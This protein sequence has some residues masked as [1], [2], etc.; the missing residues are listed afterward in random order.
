MVN[1][2]LRK[3]ICASIICLSISPFRAFAGGEINQTERHVSQSRSS[4]I[5]KVTTANLNMRTGAGTNY[6]IITTIPNGQT[7][8]VLSSSSGWHKV[9]YSN[10]TG[11]VSS[12]YLKDVETVTKYKVTTTVLN[13]RNNSS[14]TSN[15]IGKLNK[16]TVVEVVSIINNQWAKIKY[17]NSYAYCSTDYLSKVVS[18]QE[19]I[20]ESTTTNT[21]KVT[22]D[23]NLR[24][25][26]NWSAQSI[27]VIKK[28][29][30]VSVISQDSLWSY[31]K[32][33]QQNGYIYNSYLKQISNNTGT[34]TTK[35][36][37]TDA[38]NVRDA[39]NWSAK[40]LGV[41]AKG[42][43][44]DV[45][46]INNGWAKIKYNGNYGY[47]S[48]TYI[49][50]VT[51]ET[52][53]L[54]IVTESVNL[55]SEKSWSSSK[56]TVINKNEKVKVISQDK[57]WTYV[58][59]N[60]KKGYIPSK[61]VEGYVD[62][63][64]SQVENEST[65]TI[66]KFTTDN[67]NMRTG[68]GTNYSIITTIPANTEVTVLETQGSWDKIKY[69]NKIGFVNNNYLTTSGLIASPEYKNIL[70][71]LDAGHGGTDPGAIG[72]VKKLKEKDLVLE[73]TNKVN[74]ILK[75][76]GFKTILTR[77]TDTYV[78]LSSRYTKANNANADLFVSTHFNS[79]TSTS[80][81]GIETL[82]KGST[83]LASSLQNELIKST[84]ATNRGLKKR[85]DLAVLNG[86]KMP[87]ALV[88]LGFISNK[89]EEEKI[90][91]STYKDKLV[92]GIV[93][94]IIS[95]VKSNLI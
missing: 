63:D 72:L 83:T 65:S 24:K 84:G 42:T 58:E 14:L 5:T 86:T 95:Y 47:I 64:D 57:E 70:V 22:A 75:S 16:D 17:N 67:L 19:S 73:I 21:H 54:K 74:S 89:E 87:S 7:V 23:V 92:N 91:T 15:I 33:K 49:K 56:I 68:A 31:V 40:K 50:A 37:T 61:Y 77:S 28:D 45:I 4:V 11:Y 8:T 3:L 48:S 25:S 6:S 79:A 69:N 80:A 41:L 39:A 55:R 78:T 71:A 1:K 38:L 30:E 81:K 34:S 46:S 60:S 90:S 66:T 36:V 32:Y 27:T 52:S 35:Y 18:S 29:E 53:D 93:N 94:G 44:V 62:S 43:N 26:N 9:T 85:T 12:E 10:K 20:S 13:V 82:Y 88:E 2:K 76:L 59:Y 51:T